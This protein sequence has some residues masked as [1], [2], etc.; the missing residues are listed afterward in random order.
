[1]KRLIFCLI[2]FSLTQNANA[3][4]YVVGQI[5]GPVCHGIGIDVCKSHN[6]DATD[7]DGRLFTVSDKFK[8]V[9]EHHDGRCCV[10]TKVKNFGPF[11]FVANAAL[12][13]TFYEK[14][15]GEFKKVDVEYIAF[16]CIE[17]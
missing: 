12:S 5:T 13:P 1:M 16:K 4:Y 14:K 10:K 9:D 8:K 2:F 7:K 17:K 15:D 3:D 11:N 6:V